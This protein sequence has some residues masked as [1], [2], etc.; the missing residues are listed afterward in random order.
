MKKLFLLCFSLFLLP[1]AVTA[2]ESLDSI[3][4]IS[5]IEQARKLAE[6]MTDECEKEAFANVNDE[7]VVLNHKEQIQQVF[8]PYSDSPHPDFDELKLYEDNNICIKNKM[9]EII[10]K[11]FAD[12]DGKKK[13]LIKKINTFYTAMTDFY[14]EV[15]P[16]SAERMG[17]MDYK[18]IAGFQ[19]EKLKEN[20][21]EL[22]FY[23]SGGYF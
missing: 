18:N 17:I 11:R 23:T 4:K 2:Q 13:E 15:L 5:N 8:A 19:G 7:V 9:I 14:A 3:A 6:L 20:L 1:I 21:A 22:I 16:S 12:D 10:E